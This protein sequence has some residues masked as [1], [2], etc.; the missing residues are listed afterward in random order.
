LG[1]FFSTPK[2]LS[3]PPGGFVV[4]GIIDRIKKMSKLEHM[5]HSAEHVLHMSIESL[6]PG[7]KKAMGPA[8]G[9]GFYHDADLEDSGV[10]MSIEEFPKIEKRMKEII[11][12]KL[13][14]KMKGISPAEGKI[15]FKGNPYKIEWIG[16]V[17]KKQ[18][19]GS[20]EKLT[21]CEIGSKKGK[22]YDVD[23]CKGGH[24]NNTGDVGPF[25]LLSVAGAYW[26]GSEK[27]K[28]L[29]RIYGTAFPSQKDLDEYLKLQEE[30]K[31]R[32]HKIIGK[33]LDLFTFSPL[34][35]P[36]LPLWPPKGVIL[37]N[38][39][40]D[41]VWELRKARG[42]QKV[43][44]PH[45]TKKELYKTSGHWD[46]FK[47]DLFRLK[48]REGFDSA[49]KPMNCPH[50]TQIYDRKPHS[51][52]ELPQRYA[53]TTMVYRDEQSGELS[54]LARV[55]SITQDDAHVF[56]RMTQVEEEFLAIWN[57]VDDFY[58]AVGFELEVRLSLHDPDNFEAYLGSKKE[59]KKSEDIL[60]KL[61]NKRKV[62]VRE[63]V[64]EAAFYGPKIDFMAKDSLNRKWQVATIQ[65]DMSMPERFDLTCINEKG[66]KE[67]IVMIHAAIMGALERYISILI[68]HFAGAFPTWLSP[69][70]AV[71]I[72]I[73]DQNVKYANQVADTLILHSMRVEVDDRSETMQARIRDAQMQKIPYML[74]VGEKE[75]KSKSISV[76]LRS[77]EI[78]PAGGGKL[79]VD[80][81][82]DKVT[83]M[84]ENRSLD[85]WK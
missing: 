71:V 85:L 45:I 60:R 13:P 84:I 25:K 35:G 26:R 44:I 67:R 6:Y 82:V 46:K 75:E 74:I 24:V 78:P 17:E 48:S 68:E 41:F 21:I 62:E 79:K 58:G 76:R 11:K 42:Y 50:H 49:L 29:T 59:W 40:D 80:K 32:D 9:E 37:R 7:A 72:P 30:A 81:F 56:C 51:Y 4:S 15:I 61:T 54:G 38:L 66:D 19:E 22:Y 36:G 31:K 12:A 65:L 73:S 2:H 55:E 57:I 16:E 39:L 28:M 1:S 33:E 27:N 47:E 64:G 20:K 77:G 70:Q 14:I 52:K 23:I 8:T 5:R 63:E 83:K 43:E 34:V 69:V 53:N 3:L 18:K 10:K